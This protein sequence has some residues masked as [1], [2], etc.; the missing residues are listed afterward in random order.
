MTVGGDHSIATGS[1]HGV[2]SRY[3]DVKVIWVDA[4]ADILDADQTDYTGYHG[5]P[6]A[7]L[8]GVNDGS[9][10]LR[11]FEWLKRRLKPQNVVQIGWREFNDLEISTMKRYGVKYFTPDHI[12]QHGIG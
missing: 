2:L 9:K 5:T 12:D 6:L 10:T 1:I 3:Q 7:H 11:G 4:H 8:I